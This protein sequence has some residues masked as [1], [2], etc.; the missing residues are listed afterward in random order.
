MNRQSAISAFFRPILKRVL[1]VNVLRHSSEDSIDMQ[2]VATSSNID[3]E[4]SVPS[5]GV[6]NPALEDIDDENRNRYTALPASF[7]SSTLPKKMLSD[8]GRTL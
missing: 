2:Q 1:E 8:E 3:N 7:D 6:T 5:T 4:S